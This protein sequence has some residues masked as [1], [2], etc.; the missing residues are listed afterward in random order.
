[1]LTLDGGKPGVMTSLFRRVK[2]AGDNYRKDAIAAVDAYDELMRNHDFGPNVKI[3]AS[4][5]L[6]YVFRNKSELL[7]ALRHT[8]NDSNKRKLL[9]GRKG[10]K[11]GELHSDDTLDSS[12]WDAFVARMIREGKLTKA[13]FDLVQ[14]IWDLNEAQ[15]PAIQKA[16]YANFGFHMREVEAQSFTNE[17]GTYR[18][19]YVPARADAKAEP[20]AAR[21]EIDSLAE[22]QKALPITPRGFTKS[23]LEGYDRQL[24]TDLSDGGMH[25]AQVLRFVHMQEAVNDVKR[26]LRNPEV[27][28]LLMRHNRSAFRQIIDPWLSHS[29]LQ[30]TGEHAKNPTE[31]VVGMLSRSAN[32]GIMF[33]NVSNSLQNF[34]GWFTAATRV[35][36]RHLLSA[37]GSYSFGQRSQMTKDAAELSTMMANRL[38]RQMF[39]V[40]QQIRAQATQRGAVGKAV[41]WVR[42]NTYFLQRITQNVVDV[43]TWTASYNQ[44][45]AQGLNQQE[46]V[47]QADSAVRLT[48][49]ATDADDISNWEHG[50]PIQ[51]AI[52]PFQNWFI[53][54]ANNNLT[55]FQGAETVGAR[56]GVYL[57]GV[58]LPMVVAEGISQLVNGRLEDDDDDGWG[59]DMADL[60]WRSQLSGTLA[61]MPGVGRFGQLV[62]NRF[63]DDEVWNDRMPAPPFVSVMT[64][65]LDALVDIKEGKGNRRDIEDLTT[66]FG[67]LTGLPLGTLA[68]MASYQ[69]GVA[70]GDVEPEG[71][72]GETFDFLRGTVT[73]R[74]GAAGR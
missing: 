39:E 6:G 13:D 53:G 72:F 58:M 24:S 34:T 10:Q 18:G 67:N 27:E 66:F 9:L 14:S 60:W 21:Q 74:A 20:G 61:A 63:L 64:K 33:A 30:S 52:F 68:R 43:T 55:A 56:V 49:M 46:A 32:A 47:R 29:A 25:L 16:H 35:K 17:F 28:G 59:D 38:G 62:V 7:G 31:K 15:K 37:I 11:W 41:D 26:V 71:P 44:G 23:R 5:E 73:G 48:Q 65:G 40:Q 12:R 50:G 45:I 69:I 4:E 3:D 19:G 1:M 2:E 36:P 54:W 8:G 57:Y 42:Q 22:T 51:K 70:S